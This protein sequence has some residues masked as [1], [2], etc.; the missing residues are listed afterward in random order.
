MSEPSPPSRL[1]PPPAAEPA[2]RRAPRRPPPLASLTIPTRNRCAALER[3]L[4]SL[5]HQTEPRFEVVLVDDG[6]DDD[7]PEVAR[8][9]AERLDLRYLRKAHRG[10][11]S[12]RS[13]AMRAARGDLLI[14]TD[15][16]RLASPTFVADHLAGHAATGGAPYMLAGQQRGILTEWSAAAQ[17]PSNAVAT[18]VAR[19][20]HL[21][22]R[23]LEPTAELLSAA[24]LAAEPAAACAE[25]E[26]PEPWWT[27]YAVPL[28]ERYGPDLEGFAFPWTMAVGGNS[29]IPRQLAEQI[30]YLDE[31][32]VGWGLEDTDFHF[33]LCQAGARTRVLP[34]AVSYHQIHRRGPELGREWTQNARRLLQKHA[35]LELCLYVAAV[36]RRTPI[37]AASDQALAI[38]AAPR[39][40][41]DEIIRIHREAAGV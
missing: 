20:P 18:I 17:L 3:T 23:F 34:D 37:S 5:L 13:S 7:T 4:T 33:R 14:Q 19:H 35:S 24:R 41:I 12:A 40:A 27:S 11:A 29:S 8:R 21:A 15:D 22:P 16:D 31:S 9:F 32:F 2:P 39:V 36:R 25:L 26:L 10:V 30:D 6:S 28:V 1:A 38:A